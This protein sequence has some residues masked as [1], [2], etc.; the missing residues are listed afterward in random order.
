MNFG[1]HDGLKAGDYCVVEVTASNALNLKGNVNASN[2][3]NPAVSLR[4][5][6][7]IQQQQRS[8]IL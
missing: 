5:W 8:A 3:S 2:D 4:Q 7:D 6:H 1:K